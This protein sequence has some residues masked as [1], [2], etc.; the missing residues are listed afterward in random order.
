MKTKIFLAVVI[1][2]LLASVSCVKIQ[3]LPP[4]PRIEYISFTVFDTVDILGNDTKGGRLKFYFEDG[5]GDI[6]LPVP[7]AGQLYDSTNLFFTLYRKTDGVL[8]QAPANDPLKPSDY[9]IPYMERLG[10]NKILKG[11][12]SV[13][14]LYLF[15]SESDTVKYNF[16]IKDRAGNESNIATTS[17]IAVSVNDV[18]EN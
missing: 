10:Q 12:I 5:D 16:Y 2:I 8:V 1:T 7:S 6:G 4:E 9:R 3:T 18:Y 14:F 13:T 11:T 17:E 15:Y